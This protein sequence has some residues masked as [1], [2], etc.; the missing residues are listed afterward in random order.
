MTRRT[1]LSVALTL[2]ISTGV[3][4]QEIRTFKETAYGLKLYLSVHK[5]SNDAMQNPAI[6]FFHGGQAAEE[7]DKAEQDVESEIESFERERILNAANEYLAEE[8][9]TVTASICERSTGGPNDFY[10]EGDYWWPDPDNPDGPYI[11]RDGKTNPDNFTDH[12][13]AMRNMSIWVPS[14]V[15]AYKIS[16]DEKFAQH[17]IRHLKAWFVNTATR[18]NPN[19]L[20]GQAIKGRFTGRGIGIIDTIH[21]IEVARSIQVLGELGILAGGDLIALRNWFG[22]YLDWMTTHPYGIDERDHGNNHSTW[23]AV[24]VTAFAALVGDIEQME[25]CRNMYRETLL[26]DQMSANGSFEDELRRTKPYSYSLFNLEGMAMLCEL[27][28]DED[29]NLWNYELPDG[30]SIALGIEFMYP[31]VK[32]KSTWFKPPDVMYYG[33]WPA[34]HSFYL[35]AGRALDKPELITLWKTLDPD[36]T[37]DEV[38]RNCPIRQPVL[39]L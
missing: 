35:F 26:P 4:S 20:F 14:L 37:V 7:K 3:F 29:H 33:E 22:E 38:I 1:L 32:D 24:Q 6:V 27:L 39:W 28:S 23:W 2:F 30:R 19:L 25:F 34:R 31:Y 15:A 17:A 5:P 8:P 18:M 36:P 13:V 21:L 12:R 11:R 16:G 10:S 9:V